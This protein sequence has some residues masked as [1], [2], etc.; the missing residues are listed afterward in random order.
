V[1][2][3]RN[4]NRNAKAQGTCP[5]CRRD[6]KV[7]KVWSDENNMNPMCV[8]EKLFGMSDTEQ[9]LIARLAPTVHVPML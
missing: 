3:A 7:P 5:L 1:R 9:M 6:K 2:F 4:N 8:P